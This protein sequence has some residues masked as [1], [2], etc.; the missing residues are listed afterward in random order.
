M[1]IISYRSLPKACNAD[2]MEGPRNV[3]VML[4]TISGCILFVNFFFRRGHYFRSLGA[5]VSDPG[6]IPRLLTLAAE[7]H[8]GRPT[9]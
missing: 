1:A 9:T 7:R 6:C 8:Y 3:H 2:V 4:A 5:R